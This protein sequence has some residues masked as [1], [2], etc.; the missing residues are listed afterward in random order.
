MPKTRQLYKTIKKPKQIQVLLTL[1]KFQYSTIRI[2]L[3]IT[4]LTGIGV[5]GR[6]AF[7]FI[8]S[9]EP[10]TPLAILVGFFFGPVAGAVSGAS[11]F[12]ASNFLVWGGQG[13][14]TLFQA[15][16]AGAAGFVGGIFGFFSRS[17]TSAVIATFL[18][19]AAYEI[20]VTASLGFLMSFSIA[21]TALYMLTSLPFSLVH[22][23]SS[24]GFVIAF[25]EFGEQIKKAKGGV[26]VEKEI[27]GLRPAAGSGSEPADKFVP[28]F[29]KRRKFGKNK[30]K[31]YG[32]FR[33]VKRNRDSND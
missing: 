18:G 20:I 15:A 16:G 23:I 26:L 25:Y 21:F 14:W 9:V 13:P 10:L 7:Q 1:Q 5:L 30:N 3:L 6:A 2:A 17:R 8:P 11:G 19:I 32:E 12:Y 28:F 24:V 4:I 29:Y 27:L 33:L 31:S 22:I